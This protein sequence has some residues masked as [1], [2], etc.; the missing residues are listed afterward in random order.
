MQQRRNIFFYQHTDSTNI[1]AKKL[2]DKGA[3]AG[4]IVW[5]VNQSAGRGRLGKKWAS[6]AK[7]GLY[8]SFIVRPKTDFADY[9]K[10]TLV[11]G[12]ATARFLI[13]ELQNRS[14]KLALKWPNDLLLDGK[15][16]AG[17]LTEAAAPGRVHTPYAVIGIGINICHTKED[18][19]QELSNQA[20]S[21]LLETGNK[22]A[23]Q[24]LVRRLQQHIQRAVSEFENGLFPQLLEEWRSMDYLYG[25]EISCVATNGKIVSGKALGVDD[26]G[27]LFIED[28]NGSK[29]EILSGD[30][31]LAGKNAL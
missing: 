8:L 3:A 22:R 14:E 30:L 17:I 11:A 31:T 9:A 7:K 15:K 13:E 16:I 24:P 28:Q 19:P 18:F 2:A 12:V 26:N 21:L 29:H 5:A 1:R 4:T 27:V 20:T 10:I 23:L 25:K 6:C